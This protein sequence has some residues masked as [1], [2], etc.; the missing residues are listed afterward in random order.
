MSGIIIPSS[1]EDRKRIRDC[2]EEISAS[3][4]RQEAE[5]TFVKEAL[6]SLEEDVEIPKKY[7]AKMARIYHK[8]NLSELVSEIEEIE[9]LID[10][11]TKKE[12]GNDDD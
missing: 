3:Y 11:V 9:A 1:P 2:M 6:A 5:K 7:L 8:Q 12:T 4:L 10:V